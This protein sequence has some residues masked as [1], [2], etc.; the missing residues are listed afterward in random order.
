MQMRM[1][2]FVQWRKAIQNPAKQIGKFMSNLSLYQFSSAFYVIAPK[3]NGGTAAARPA[4][5]SGA[6]PTAWDG[7]WVRCPGIRARRLCPAGMR[8]A[9]LQP[10][11][12]APQLSRR[13]FRAAPNLTASHPESTDCKV[14]KP[15]QNS[16]NSSNAKTPVKLLVVAVE[17][18]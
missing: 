7:R 4:G 12:P 2:G 8:G 14:N 5:S 17:R 11:V 6:G 10:A 9:R 15:T 1:G 13:E 16:G 18:T 3:V